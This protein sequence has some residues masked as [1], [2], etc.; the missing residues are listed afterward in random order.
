[1]YAAEFA[2]DPVVSARN[3]A[4]GRQVWTTSLPGGQPGTSVAVANR[5]VIVTTREAVVAVDEETG[6]RQWTASVSAGRATAP[7]VLGGTVFVASGDGS[8]T[9]VH[10]LE[11]SSGAEEWRRT[12]DG[13]LGGSPAATERGL[14]VPIGRRLY[15]FNRFRGDDQW[16]S[17]FP[18]PV[19]TP[20]VGERNDRIYVVDA[21]WTAYS[22]QEWDGAVRWE[23]SVADGSSDAPP[24]APTA[25]GDLVCVGSPDGLYGL[26]STTGRRRWQFAHPGPMTPPTVTDNV[27]YSGS[28]ADGT[29]VATGLRTGDRQW[30]Y[31]TG[32]GPLP[33]GGDEGTGTG[34]NEAADEG[35]SGED[36]PARGRAV[37]SPVVPVAIGLFVVAADGVH[38]IGPA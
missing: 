25:A 4:T 9:T 20:A 15:T 37:L 23:A 33:G 26:S 21:D 22:V 3:A 1:L 24:D 11:A 34:T 14:H 31:E 36:A 35:S 32:A 8:A 2:D 18:A 17:E 27:V 5:S 30:S 6:E 16:S 12:I 13:T 28:L 29:V 38:G 7:V 10:A 19:G